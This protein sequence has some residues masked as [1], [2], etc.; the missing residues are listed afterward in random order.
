M[1]LDASRASEPIERG[2]ASRSAPLLLDDPALM[3]A[4]DEAGYDLGSLLGDGPARDGE[5]LARGARY[6]EMEAVIATD[7][8]ASKRRDPASGRRAQR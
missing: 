1:S 5:S 7:V 3:T 2:S 4:L 6:R 8:A